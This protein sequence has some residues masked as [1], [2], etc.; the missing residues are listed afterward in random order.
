MIT[1]ETTIRQALE[2]WANSNTTDDM[3]DRA[4]KQVC[5]RFNFPN[6]VVTCGIVYLEGRGTIEFPPMPIQQ[7][8]KL[9]QEVIAKQTVKV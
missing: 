7:V 2:Q 5:H 4:M 1:K 8:A 9:F 6:A 3:D